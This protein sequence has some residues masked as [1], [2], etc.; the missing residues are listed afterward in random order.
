MQ[1]KIKFAI[2]T[3]LLTIFLAGCSSGQSPSS[4]SQGAD[5]QMSKKI[6]F[7]TATGGLGDKSFND[8]G[9]AG[10]E[11]L[12]AETGVPIDV[13]EPKDIADYEGYQW[14]FAEDGNY[15]V[16]VSMGFDQA[17]AL[18]VVADEFPEQNFILIDNLINKPNVASV[19]VKNEEGS[20]QIGALAGLLAKE[21]K[22]PNM[23]K[24]NIIGM[25]GGMDIPLIRTFVAGYMAGAK[26]VNPDVEILVSY[27]GDWND[28]AKA[29]ELAKGMYE[30]GADIIW[31]GAGGSGLGVFEAAKK[32]DRYA[33]GVDSNQ[34]PLDPKHIVA[35]SIR[36]LDNIVYKFT[37][38][39]LK[40]DFSGGDYH[41]GLKEQA[42]E[43]VTEGSEVSIAQEI[44]DKV[45]AVTQKIAEGKL[46]VPTTIEEVDGFIQKYGHL[47]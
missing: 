31:Q 37:T 6:G 24:K 30:K 14:A 32:Y 1:K 19:V 28:P 3:V 8:L 42:A 7:I 40:G 11:K 20:F 15:A 2:V 46:I 21:G 16:I 47:E 36:R 39:A 44:M 29:A 34:N 27:V 38:D 26:Y 10:A 35:S 41:F 17:D 13:V 25:V 5:E 9:Y 45:A 4:D 12:K 23:T 43:V 33:M 18:S 22:L